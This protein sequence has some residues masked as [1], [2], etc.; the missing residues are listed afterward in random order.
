MKLV[1]GETR[2]IKILTS[3]CWKG[4]KLCLYKVLSATF[5]N[6]RGQ[7]LTTTCASPPVFELSGKFFWV[8][9]IHKSE[10]AGKSLGTR[11]STLPTLVYYPLMAVTTG[12]TGTSVSCY[13]VTILSA[14]HRRVT[15]SPVATGRSSLLA[16]N[17]QIS[18]GAILTT[19][20]L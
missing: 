5:Q 2:E 16:K 3:I 19:G 13:P 17:A 1:T 8:L 10:S 4:Q 15:E 9:L 6:A 12:P 14:F 20:L 11:W 7:W 18:A